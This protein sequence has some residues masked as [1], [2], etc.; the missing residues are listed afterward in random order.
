MTEMI[1]ARGLW[2][3][4]LVAMPTLLAELQ[5]RCRR[6]MRIYF[7]IYHFPVRRYSRVPLMR[8]NTNPMMPPMITPAQKPGSPSTVAPYQFPA[9]Q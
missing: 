7:G 8:P 3:L 6:L 9:R 1:K 4:P 5:Q 2:T